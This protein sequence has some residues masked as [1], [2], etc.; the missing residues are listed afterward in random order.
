[1]NQ[2]A[3]QRVGFF[4]GVAA[5]VRATVHAFGVLLSLLG[6]G[7]AALSRRSSGGHTSSGETE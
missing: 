4:Q 6:K 3:T 5:V 2:P 1:M 7:V